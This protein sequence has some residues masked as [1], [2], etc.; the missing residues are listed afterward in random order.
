MDWQLFVQLVAGVA[1]VVAMTTILCR[2][3]HH[4]VNRLGAALLGCGAWWCFWQLAW[5]VSDSAEGAR[6]ALR[7]SSFGW[8]AL[9]PLGL[10]TLMEASGRPH[11]RIRQALPALYLTVVPFSGIVWTTTWLHPEVVPMAWGWGYTLGPAWLF[12]FSLTVGCLLAGLKV[13]HDRWWNAPS[14]VERQQARWIGTGILLTISV[15]SLTD[16]ILP[17]LGIQVPRLG[18]AAYAVFGIG[19][20]ALFARD[21]YTIF[22]PGNFAREIVE[23]VGAGLALVELDG[24][25]R[26]AN[27]ALAEMAGV[28]PDALVGCSVQELFGEALGDPPAE[29]HELECQLESMSGRAIPVSTTC[30]TLRN[31]RGHPIGLILAVHDLSEVVGLRQRVLLSGRMAAVG[32]LAA[33]IAHEINTP[34]AWVRSN[35]GRLQEHWQ[36]V[37]GWA[38]GETPVEDPEALLAEGEELIQES[39]EG[40]DRTAAIVRDVRELSHGGHGEQ[41]LVDVNEL[42]ETIQRVAAAQLRHVRIERDYGEIPPIVCAPREIQQVFL[43]LLVNAADAVGDRGLVRIAT[44]CFDDTLHVGFQDDGCGIAPDCL[45]RIFDPFFTTKPVGEGTGLGLPLSYEIVRRHGGEIQIASERDVGSCFTVVLPLEAK[46][47]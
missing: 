24:R 11:P 26:T 19:L 35:L 4:K 9:G 31:K 28:P 16:G 30:S 43:N 23:N 18:T 15:T 22:T 38:R 36:V 33:G 3:P 8:I 34:L 44:R 32:Q 2:D 42:L 12:Y 41:Q 5:N 7:A 40:V 27:G 6:W 47:G 20:A 17:F 25:L 45:D 39:F 37:S 21:G 10:H 46:P 14:W 29:H 13:A 1:L